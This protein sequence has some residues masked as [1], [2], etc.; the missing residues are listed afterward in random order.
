MRRRT[1]VI[2]L[3]LLAFLGFFLVY[4]VVY[5]VPGSASED[6]FTVR[7]DGLGETAEQ[8]AQVV[9]VLEQATPGN[10][11]GIPLQFPYDVRTFASRVR[12]E[13]LATQLRK[14]GARAEVVRRRHWTDFYF[15]QA[16]GFQV[17]RQGRF[18][19]FR[20]VPNNPFLWECLRNSLVLA[21]T[22]T[23]ATTLLCLPL[24]RWFVRYRFAG[25][26]F[27][28]T[29]LLVPL[30][31]PPFVGAIGMERFLGRFGTFNLW[32]MRLGVLTPGRPIDWLGEGGFFG[33]MLMQVLHLYPILYLNLAAA[34]ANVDPTLEDAA[35]NLGAGESYLFRTVT[36][37]LLLPGYFAG[38]TL[39]FV[40][41]FTDLGTPLVFGVESVIPVQIFNQVTDPQRTNSTA[42][43]LVVVTLLVTAALFYAARWVV[44]RS[45]Y[46][47]GG[48]GAVASPARAAGWRRTLLI[49]AS[50]LAL[51]LLAVLPS[52]GVVLTACAGRWTF[53]PLPQ[54]YTTGYF[55]EVWSNHVAALSIRNSVLY[56]TAS[57]FLDLLL[58]VTIAWLI[59]RRP[60][61]LTGV[62]DGL[63]TLPL[64]LPG[65]VLAFGYLTCYSN[66]NLGSFLNPVVNPVPLLIVAYA[67]RRLP[68]LTRSA[69][70]GLQQIA[71]VMEEA[72]E[73]LGAGR[74]RVLRTVTVPLIAANVVA[75]AV[76]TFAFALLEV[77]D[78]LMLA[79]EEKYFPI[80]RAI[81]G[82]L[83][84]PD[85]GDS[86][87][88]ALAVIAM[89]LLGAS[90]LVASLLLGRKMGELFRA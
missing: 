47:G 21:L 68:Y 70:A 18:P 5:V 10:A 59:A 56:S 73:N 15:R 85:D 1:L 19:F 69:L 28:A 46:V 54:T 67:V 63:A 75:G 71:P 49:H 61:W 37:P 33:V 76:L 34:W 27:L 8:K 52:V 12:A 66:W 29:L 23:L 74:W 38:A 55:Q 64:A 11:S 16:L 45:A 26:T 17:E 62:L 20:L 41:A 31:V 14:A 24:A 80:T 13:E 9:A 65:L 36:F 81:L 82:L 44:G 51:T 79:R 58:G 57:T 90:L 22:T 84:R 6:D 42:Y 32:L 7:L 2:E 88:S 25:R 4:P 72:A 30:I 86:I 48:K 3:L 89:G 35:R 43:A 87:A 39:V 40:W 78:S 60:S 53:S 83:M 77:S 50:V